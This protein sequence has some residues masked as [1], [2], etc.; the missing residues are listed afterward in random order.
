MIDKK[1]IS[2]LLAVIMLLSTFTPIVY[3]ATTDEFL[4]EDE[5]LLEKLKTYDQNG[6]GKFSQEEMDEM[7]IITIPEEAKSIKGLEHANNIEQIIYYYNG[8]LID[9]SAL[10]K[11]NII[12]LTVYLNKEYETIDISFIKDFKNLVSLAI[13]SNYPIKVDISSLAEQT[14]LTSLSL[15]NVLVPDYEEIKTLTNLKYF[16]NTNRDYQ[17]TS[18][19]KNILDISA[20][21]NFKNLEYI[22]ITG[23][24]I[25]NINAVSSLSKLTSA[26]FQNCSGISDLSALKNCK[27]LTRISVSNSDIEN[28]E[29]MKELP[30]LISVDLYGTKIT[31]QEKLSLLSFKDYNA[32]IG[33]NFDIDLQVK[34]SGLLEV[35][36]WNYV[37]ENEDIVIANGSVGTANSVG[38]TNIKITLKEDETISRTMKVTVSGI[39][40]NQA[41][42]TEVG[43]S[44]LISDEL[45]LNANGDL[46]R[47]YENAGKTQKIDTDVKK[48]VY[49][50]IYTDNYE[51]FNYTLTQKNDGS[52]KYVFNGVER[53]IENVK[54]IYNNGYL[55]TVGVF[56]IINEDGTWERKVNNVEKIVGSYLVKNDGKTYTTADKLVCNFKI[57]DASY[58]RVV[59]ENKNV[60]RIIDGKEPEK[61]GENFKAFV[62]EDNSLY[63]TTDGKIMND[64]GVE[65]QYL[66]EYTTAYGNTFIIDKNN[67][68]ILNKKVILT[69]V[70]SINIR[71]EPSNRVTKNSV[72]IVRDDGSVWILKI[73]GDAELTKLE[74]Q[75]DN[76]YF[77]NIN[78]TTKP[79][80]GVVSY[81]AELLSGFDIKNLSVGKALAVS[82]FKSGFTAKAYKD[83]A[84]LT[85]KEN[86]STGTIIKLY[87][88]EGELVEEYT[89]LVYGD[90]TGSGN[91]GA[92]DALAIIKNR[93]G[94]VL[95]DNALNLE[96]ARVTENSRKSGGIPTSADAL[97]IIKAKLTMDI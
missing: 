36:K 45:I 38:T 96:A 15:N 64:S 24:E 97:A 44:T 40:S 61:I 16:T 84:E 90:V 14:K 20:I 41:K 55:S 10:N 79:T 49:E 59:D 23:M 80:A 63:Y 5:A 31:E 81:T 87:N 18:Q 11:D 50:F 32:Y 66:A 28:I 72:L 13:T 46:W 52:V 43:K 67:Q 26:S 34:I 12:G 93:T 78:Y 83:G 33:E 27:E 71:Y 7:T 29:F 69:D 85:A 94:K 60:W 68:L 86:V 9:L 56:Y 8:T 91:P 39:S 37:S 74:S 2:L 88:S 92:K 47:V 75:N 17:S 3:A 65:E 19:T 77:E 76:V 42:G 48:Y 22:Y 35:E 1:I 53:S 95:I 25:N 70:V 51:A 62:T 21:S 30:N 82:N 73:S 89:A 57:I 4:I 54:D 6:D 58:N